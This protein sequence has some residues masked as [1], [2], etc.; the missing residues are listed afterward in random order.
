MGGLEIAVHFCNISEVKC[1]SHCSRFMKEKKSFD[2]KILSS[3]R[4]KSPVLVF[5]VV[6]VTT[7]RY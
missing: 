3:R 7:L 2:I 6:L 4:P 1:V 5:N